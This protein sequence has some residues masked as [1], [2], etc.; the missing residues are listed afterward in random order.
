MSINSY[1][2]HI[3]ILPEDDANA[4]IARGFVQHLSV[5]SECI[6]IL[7]VCGGWLKVLDQFESVH[8][9]RLRDYPQCQM[10]LLID[11]DKNENRLSNAR[12]RVL[13]GVLE[14]V[15]VLGSRTNPEDLR[16]HEGKSYETIGK[17]LADECNQNHFDL[18]NHTLLKH[19]LSEV[20]RLQNQVKPIL[21]RQPK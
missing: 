15:F 3:L 16:R 19:N 6:Q 5:S 11:F 9:K 1:K 7:P 21:F 13:P 17:T 20:E 4:D 8:A 14:R 2:P 10:I 18:W 12:Q